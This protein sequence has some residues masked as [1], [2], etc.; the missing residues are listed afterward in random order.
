MGSGLSCVDPGNVE[1]AVRSA[2]SATTEAAD[3]TAANPTATTTRRL[4]TDKD[5]DNS[6]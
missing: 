1:G 4:Q 2:L 6:M 3:A 5:P